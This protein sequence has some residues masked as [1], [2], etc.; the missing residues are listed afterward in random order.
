MIAVYQVGNP[1]LE[2]EKHHG[3]DVWGI[4]A[5]SEPYCE[6]SSILITTFQQTAILFPGVA[7]ILKQS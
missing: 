6:S 1:M 7:R 4:Y 2:D 3:S 5:N